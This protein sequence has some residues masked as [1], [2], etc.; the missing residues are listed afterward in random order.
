M[1]LELNTD[2]SHSLPNKVECQACDDENIILDLSL[3][4][5]A[6]IEVIYAIK[7]DSLIDFKSANDLKES[8]ID[9]FNINDSFF[10]DICQGFSQSNNDITLEDRIH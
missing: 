7:N 3:C 5:D 8:G 10:N 9:V 6:E 4:N 1:Q 2:N